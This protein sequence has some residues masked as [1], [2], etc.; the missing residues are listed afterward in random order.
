[1]AGG[2]WVAA[3]AMAVMVAAPAAAQEITLAEA[4]RLSELHQPR[5]V[6]ALGSARTSDARI[7]TA[8]G[9]FLP[10]LSISANRSNSYSESARL[11]PATGI[12]LESGS[13]NQSTS[14]TINT[15][16]DLFAG[17]R[18]TAELSSARAAGSAAEA[19][20]TDA[21]FQEALQT[22]NQ[23]FDALS[24]RRLVAVREV[25]LRRAEEQ[26]AASV[27][28][29]AAGAATRSD[30]LRSL[31]GVGNAQ[32][33][34]V[35]ARSQL[36]SAEANLG[37]LV[38]STERTQAADDSAFY[39]L[40]TPPDAAAL[41]TEAM[42][43]AP[44]V[45]VA[46]ANTLAAEASLKASRSGYWPSLTLSGSAGINGTERNDW[47]MLAQN[48]LSLSFQWQVFNRFN[49]EQG[50]VQ[51]QVALENARATE[52]EARRAVI[53]SLTSQLADLEAARLRIEITGRSVVASTEDLRVQQERYRL[54]ASTILDVLLTQEALTQAEV[55][56]VNAQFDYLRARAAIEALVG[57]P[58]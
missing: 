39:Q 40:L 54:G 10:N 37:R 25:S 41:M 11:D 34:L 30:S 29:L 21:R 42:A 58:L 38:G 3:W 31:V 51:Q 7:R 16:V 26:M 36:A 2:R 43:R 5:V 12:L 15:S 55:D 35:T 22:T 50:V 17:F 49:R 27:A 6:Q 18:R 9:A 56:A 14:S 45:L 20:L 53:A 48:N 47:K 1:M 44:S 8:K 4:I 32:L 57:R 28:R 24:A 23:F 19:S 46:E 33:Q 13:L 52:A